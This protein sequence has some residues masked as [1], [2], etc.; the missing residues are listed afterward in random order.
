MVEPNK[1]QTLSQRDIESFREQ[2]YHIARGVFDAEEL[3]RLRQGYDYILELAARTDLPEDVL[4]GKGGEVH[5]HLQT[6]E[7]QSGPD[8]VRYLR[9]VQWPALIHP[10]FEEIRNSAKFAA[11][12]EPL[13]GTSL[14]QYINQI[15]FKMP[16]GDIAYPWHQDIRPTP[17]FRDQVNNYVQTVI[18]VDEAAVENGCL[19][20]VP[21]SHKQGDLKVQRYAQRQIED[22]VDVSTAVPCEAT[23]GDVIL[24]T[25]Y[26][27]HGS[28]PN[29][30]DRPRRSYIN[31]FVRAASCDV[32][33][34]AFLDGKPVPVTSDHDYHS[35]RASCESKNKPFC[36][37]AH[38]D[39]GFKG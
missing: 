11:L 4:Q 35:I 13:I 21:G 9:K 23:P 25:S 24:F 5:V 19:H 27:V 20:I 1:M 22:L 17:A 3:A 32:G 26:T 37:G 28:T 39:A 34:W 6:P 7:S 31:G 16:G 33:K 18:A 38:N 30:T 15:N 2:G 36:D 29:T 14:K 8:M 12:L 10:A